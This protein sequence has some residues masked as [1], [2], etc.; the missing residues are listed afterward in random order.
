MSFYFWYVFINLNIPLFLLY[1]SRVSLQFKFQFCKVIYCYNRHPL[2]T[3]SAHAVL[4]RLV[5]G[6]WHMRL[7]QF[8]ASLVLAGNYQ[9]MFKNKPLLLTN[10]LFSGMAVSSLGLYGFQ[11]LDLCLE[12]ICLWYSFLIF[13]SSW[14]GIKIF[15]QISSCAVLIAIWRTVALRKKLSTYVLLLS[16]YSNYYNWFFIQSFHPLILGKTNPDNI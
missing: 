13:E 8:G 12:G 5:D 15:K 6:L 16:S 2:N 9:L 11:F 10:Q 7:L 4:N 1:L 14:Y 3:F